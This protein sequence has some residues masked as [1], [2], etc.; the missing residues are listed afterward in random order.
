MFV[1]VVGF[2]LEGG[3]KIVLYMKWFFFLFFLLD[4][5]FVVDCSD[6]CGRSKLMKGGLASGTFARGQAGL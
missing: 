2:L 5:R 6:G 1:L 3:R 4:G